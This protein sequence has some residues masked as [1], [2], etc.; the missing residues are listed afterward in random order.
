MS[1]IKYYATAD[2]KVSSTHEINQSKQMPIDKNI[3]Q[4][5]YNPNNPHGWFSDLGETIGQRPVIKKYHV[6][7]ETKVN[8][9]AD[10]QVN[11]NFGCKQPYFCPHC[12]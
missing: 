1:L 3:D 12:R 9:P 10:R 5:F 6:G 4:R 2:Q 7:N 8:Q 11:G